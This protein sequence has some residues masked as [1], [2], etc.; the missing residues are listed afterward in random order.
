MTSLAK[1][2]DCYQ[3][4]HVLIAVKSTC[5]KFSRLPN[6][7]K[8]FNYSVNKHLVNSYAMMWSSAHYFKV[9]VHQILAELCPFE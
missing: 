4:K 9:R 2:L 6:F 8:K 5:H 7:P 3:Q 1:F